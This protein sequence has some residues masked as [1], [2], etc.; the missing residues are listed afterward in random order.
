MI[1]IIPARKG[2]E[3]ALSHAPYRLGCVVRSSYS[4]VLYCTYIHINIII[5]IIWWHRLRWDASVGAEFLEKGNDEREAGVKTVHA[6]PN[7][8]SATSYTVLY[9][10]VQYSTA[11]KILSNLR[12]NPTFI[13]RLNSQSALDSA[14]NLTGTGICKGTV[15]NK[16]CTF[17]HCPH[18]PCRSHLICSAQ[19]RHSIAMAE[20]S[21][22]NPHALR[23]QEVDDP[24]PEA[25]TEATPADRDA[26][27]ATELARIRKA[28]TRASNHEQGSSASVKKPTSRL[29]SFTSGISKFWK[30]QISVTVP[31]ATCRDHLGTCK[32]ASHKRFKSF[33]SKSVHPHSG[34]RAYSGHAAYHLGIL[35]SYKV[36]HKII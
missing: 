4:T 20:I 3:R 26:R 21:D 17:T 25:E 12:E 28:Y 29:G 31:H 5:I 32:S 1:R 30:H 9:S 36:S 18:N 15:V 24:L 35:V 14:K 8:Y 27:E 16:S 10:T 7:S 23:E 2:R 33:L 13:E 34:R 22:R 6:L 11:F 19:Q